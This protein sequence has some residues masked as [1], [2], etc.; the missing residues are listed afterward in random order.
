[1]ISA[2]L[3]SWLTPAGYAWIAYALV[4]ATMS[5]VYWWAWGRIFRN[6]GLKVE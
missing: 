2:E 6:V 5:V 3:A 4:G 1:M